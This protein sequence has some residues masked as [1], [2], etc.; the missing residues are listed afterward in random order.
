MQ[1]YA[2]LDYRTSRVGH[3]DLEEAGG[4][5]RATEGQAAAEDQVFHCRADAVVQ[6]ISGTAS[7]GVI[8]GRG[9]EGLIRSLNGEESI[10]DGTISY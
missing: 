8:Q 9:K 4:I 1:G 6:R 3:E 10:F 7:T 2:L 5:E